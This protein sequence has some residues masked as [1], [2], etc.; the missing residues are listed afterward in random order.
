LSK[1][2]RRK[3]KLRT[4][5]QQGKCRSSSQLADKSGVSLERNRSGIFNSSPALRNGSACVHTYSLGAHGLIR[6]R[7]GALRRALLIRFA[8]PGLKP[9]ARPPGRAGISAEGF[10]PLC[11]IAANSLRSPP[12]KTGGFN[13]FIQL[14]KNRYNRLVAPGG[15]AI[16]TSSRS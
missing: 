1:M 6:E 10:L 14:S 12:V 11:G 8:H 15:I 16:R 5:R 9:K 3:A 4:L 7:R 13:P 2:R